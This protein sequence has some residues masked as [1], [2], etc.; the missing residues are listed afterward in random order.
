MKSQPSVHR[1]GMHDDRSLSASARRFAVRPQFRKYSNVEGKKPFPCLSIW[2][3]S[4]M[5]TSTP[6]S[7]SPC[8]RR[9]RRR[10]PSYRQAQSRRTDKPY[11][12]PKFLQ[13][14]Y[15]RFRH[16]AVQDISDDRNLQPLILP[17]FSRI[18]KRS[19]RAWVGC[20]F[21]RRPRLRQKLRGFSQEVGCAG[22][23]MPQDDKVCSQR[24]IVL[25]VSFRVSP[26]P[27][28]LLRWKYLSNQR[29]ISL[30][31]AQRRSWSLWKAH[32]K[33]SPL[34]CPAAQ[35][36]FLCPFPGHL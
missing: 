33:D 14:V 2:I 10:G 1:A 31:Q 18:V 15:V 26:S 20:S 5:T 3:L 27:H 23:R 6:F 16:P 36:P 11:I 9:Y 22:E 24:C 8:Q 28:C 7:R 29:S 21:V 12:G 19:S 4:I 30:L 25:A 32:K 17:F 35:G 13:R 34:S